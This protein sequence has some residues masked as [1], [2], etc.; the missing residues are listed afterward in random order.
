[1]SYLYTEAIRSRLAADSLRRSRERM[2]AADMA[3][4]SLARSRR[5][6][7]QA[8]AIRVSRQVAL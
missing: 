7:A 1:M 6:A 2:I 5:A 3:A 4:E 8:D